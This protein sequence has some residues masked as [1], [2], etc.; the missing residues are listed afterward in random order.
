M[1]VRRKLKLQKR[2]EIGLCINCGAEANGH[3]LCAECRERATKQM[4]DKRGNLKEKNLCRECGKIKVK[5]NQYYCDVCKAKHY[6]KR[7]CREEG[8]NNTTKRNCDFCNECLNLRR[9]GIKSSNV[10]FINCSVCG[11]M[12][13]SRREDSRCCSKKCGF[14]IG[15][16]GVNVKR[17]ERICKECGS[18]FA[19]YNLN[20]QREYCSKRC[21]KK[22]GS[23]NGKHR[24]R[25]LKK[26][27]FIETVN[28]DV[29]FK[30]DNG[31]CKLC[32]KKLDRE[33]IVPHPLAV[34]IDHIVPLSCGGEHSYR[35]TQ[36]ACFMCNSLKGNR[37][38]EGGEQLR[39]FG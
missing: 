2:R 3:S 10:Y 35:N 37:S 34:T 32:D 31:R 29:L 27:N 8:C 28:I 5:K 26:K 18:I 1:A 12:F 33:R 17:V 22:A 24:R 6:G 11:T 4:R 13:T 19:T 36:L 30:R 14:M 20:T 39:L 7:I 21:S 25:I 16:Y 9:F 38:V 15:Y 23:R